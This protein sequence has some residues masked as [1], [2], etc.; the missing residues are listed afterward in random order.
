MCYGASVTAQKK[1]SGYFTHLQKHFENKSNF[2][3]SKLSFGASHFDYA[4]YGYAKQMLE[5]KPDIALIDWLTPSM[6]KFSLD[7]IINLNNELIKLGCLPIWVNFPRKDDLNC[8]REC[9]TQVKKVALKSGAIF[10]DLIE[11]LSAEKIENEYLR[12]IVHTTECGAEKYASKIIELID[13][14]VISDFELKIL[15]LD[16]PIDIFS[17][18]DIESLIDKGSPLLMKVIKTTDLSP[19]ELLLN[20]RIGPNSCFID[21]E[22]YDESGV[23]IETKIINPT[24]PWC[25]YSRDMILPTVRLPYLKES[26]SIKLKHGGDNALD[27]VKLKGEVREPLEDNKFI[28]IY[29]IACNMELE[30]VKNAN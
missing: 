17:I 5:E 26:Y 22:I 9:Y 1:Q 13:S 27:D 4:G 11:Q 3:L 28:H 25:H 30:V 14:I 23:L 29:N 20:T 10:F 8:Q 15:P 7:K 12:D 2:E 16:K 19:I 6:K 21:I 24:D 18:Y